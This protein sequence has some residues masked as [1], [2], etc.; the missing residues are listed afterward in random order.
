[1]YLG[2]AQHIANRHSVSRTGSAYQGQAQRIEDNHIVL[3]KSTAYRGQ[4]QSIRDRRG[5]LKTKN[6][7]IPCP[8]D[9]TWPPYRWVQSECFVKRE[10]ICLNTFRLLFKFETEERSNL[11][12]HP[13]FLLLAHYV[14]LPGSFDRSRFDTSRFGTNW[15]RFDMTS[16]RLQP[17]R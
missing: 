11:F 2:Q 8:R 3:R 1:M 15:G 5:G 6:P 17:K 9:K 7:I 4:A 16:L 14:R 10:D 13:I 12:R